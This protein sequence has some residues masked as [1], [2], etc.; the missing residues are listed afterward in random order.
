M[1]RRELDGGGGAVE[2]T[3]ATTN[4]SY[5]RVGG[6]GTVVRVAGVRES[7]FFLVFVRLCV[8]V[9]CVEEALDGEVEEWSRLSV[10][11]AC[12]EGGFYVGD[13]RELE[14][15][16][17]GWGRGW[18]EDFRRESGPDGSGLCK[19][20]DVEWEVFSV[21][22]SNQYIKLSVMDGGRRDELKRYSIYL[23]HDVPKTVDI[24]IVI[25]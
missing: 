12:E 8:A 15:W 18:I 13:G 5:R 4:T 11:I 9:E 17:G 10:L 1:E 24:L 19:D 7:F 3:T 22:R 20:W 25:F 23:P 21:G 2:D 14:W 6:K 16:R